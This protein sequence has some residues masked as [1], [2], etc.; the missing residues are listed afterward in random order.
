M[1][2]HT[3][4]PNIRANHIATHEADVQYKK[5]GPEINYF[6]VWLDI[7]Y[8]AL[9]ELTFAVFVIGEHDCG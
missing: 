9:S 4:D 6:K 1:R 5:Y 8:A 2:H 7:Y 3:K